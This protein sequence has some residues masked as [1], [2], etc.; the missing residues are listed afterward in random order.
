MTWNWSWRLTVGSQCGATSRR[1]PPSG[2]RAAPSGYTDGAVLVAHELVGRAL[3]RAAGDER[4]PVVR[5]QRLGAGVDDHPVGLHGAD[6][7]RGDGKRRPERRA[8]RRDLD[9]AV[10]LVHEEVGARLDL[11]EG[12]MR[13][14]EVMGAGAAARDDLRREARCRQRVEERR[15]PVPLLARPSRAGRQSSSRAGDGRNRPAR[16]DS[17]AAAGRDAAPRERHRLRRGS[18]TPSRPSPMSMSIR[19]PIGA[20]A[21]C[22]GGEGSTP[23]RLSTTTMKTVGLLGAPRRAAATIDG[24]T[25]RRGDEQRRAAP[26]RPATSASRTVAQHRPTAPAS[27]CRLPIDAGLV[28]LG[29]RP[30]LASGAAASSPSSRFGLESVEVDHQRRRR[31]LARE[32]LAVAPDRDGGLVP[33]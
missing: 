5:R 18:P 27:I 14:V 23:A 22:T 7:P 24:V 28:R 3:R 33:E 4:R 20:L 21:A 16:R 15:E 32:R 31:E 2:G 1:S 9:L 29:V 17:G 26:H 8:A 11:G 12:P 10:L 6:H 30:E 13:E 19:T 25:H